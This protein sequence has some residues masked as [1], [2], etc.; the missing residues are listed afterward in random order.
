MQ[1]VPDS[2]LGRLFPEQSWQQHAMH[3]SDPADEELCTIEPCIAAMQSRA[4]A[5]TRLVF[6]CRGHES[7]SMCS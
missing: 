3:D 5:L 6:A 4:R 7:Q 2:V 1:E